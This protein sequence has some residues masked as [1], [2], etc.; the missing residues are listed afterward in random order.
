[1]TYSVEVYIPSQPKYSGTFNISGAE[2]AALE[3]Q[4]NIYSGMTVGAI[5]ALIIHHNDGSRIPIIW[6]DKQHGAYVQIKHIAN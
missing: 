5:K 4:N 2:K 3:V 1:M 6:C